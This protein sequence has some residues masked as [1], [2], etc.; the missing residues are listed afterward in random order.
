MLYYFSDD[1]ELFYSNKKPED[2]YKFINDT[3]SV[4]GKCALD[5]LCL[6]DFS[7]L[8]SDFATGSTYVTLVCPAESGKFV[9]ILKF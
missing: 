1:E 7:I 6:L 4:N 8:N 3:Y 9:Q 5:T 2:S